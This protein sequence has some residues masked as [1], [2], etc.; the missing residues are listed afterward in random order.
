MLDVNSSCRAHKSVV[1]IL[2]H[3]LVVKIQGDGQVRGLSVVNLVVDHI[4]DHAVDVVFALDDLRPVLEYGKGLVF[5]VCDVLGGGVG[6]ACQ[7]L[8]KTLDAVAPVVNLIAD[9]GHLVE[10]V[11]LALF[12][13]GQ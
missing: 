6:I 13:G 12:K 5:A 4:N 2:V 7:F 9:L 11:K 3:K 10:I 8:D 1:E